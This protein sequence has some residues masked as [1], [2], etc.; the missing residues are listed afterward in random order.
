[1]EFSFM[2]CFFP[3][4]FQFMESRNFHEIFLFTEKDFLEIPF[5]G[6][7]FLKFSFFKKKFTENSCWIR[8]GSGWPLRDFG[9]VV[10]LYQVG[11]RFETLAEGVLTVLSDLP[12]IFLLS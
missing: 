3:G 8:S 11:A 9:V 12:C 4:I 5:P 7:F 6:T 2:Q 10:Q 1:M